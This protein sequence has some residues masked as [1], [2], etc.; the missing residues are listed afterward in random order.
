[1]SGRSMSRRIR[2]SPGVV[3]GRGDP[4]SATAPCAGRADLTAVLHSGLRLALPKP[5]STCCNPSVHRPRSDETEMELALSPPTPLA[6][7]A[8]V[9]VQPAREDADG[10]LVVR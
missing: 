2:P 5:G 4:A 7:P 9:P 6:P 8:R 3:F 1:A 10:D